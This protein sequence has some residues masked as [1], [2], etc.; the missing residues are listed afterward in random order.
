MLCH[1]NKWQWY[2]IINFNYIYLTFTKKKIRHYL[3]FLYILV[4]SCNYHLINEKFCQ[5]HNFHSLGIHALE[6]LI[7]IYNP[8]FI[9]AVL[10]YLCMITLNFDLKF[11]FHFKIFFSPHS[12]R[13]TREIIMKSYHLISA[14]YSLLQTG[15]VINSWH[16][17]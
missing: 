9:T 7:F 17:Q 12:F 15:D 3:G 13:F 8:K 10:G 6:A 2:I 11:S 16:L 5:L 14:S 1:K 4:F